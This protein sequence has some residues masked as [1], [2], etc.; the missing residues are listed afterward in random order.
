MHTDRRLEEWASWQLVHGVDASTG[1]SA[2]VH[3]LEPRGGIASS[4]P[5]WWDKTP[6][7]I[8]TTH[9]LLSAWLPVKALWVLMVIYGMPGS[10][11]RKCQQLKLGDRTVRRLKA[12]AREIVTQYR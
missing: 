7:Y 5:L 8:L 10:D 12:R 9:Q 4:R 2:C 11:T 1:D 6:D 3:L